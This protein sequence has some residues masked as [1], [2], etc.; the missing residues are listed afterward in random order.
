MHLQFPLLAQHASIKI[1]RVSTLSKHVAGFD[2]I[3]NEKGCFQGVLPSG[4]EV[5]TAY[6]TVAADLLVGSTP[7]ISSRRWMGD[8]CSRRSRALEQSL[9]HSA[10][11]GQ[12][13]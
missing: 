6:F 11:L 1:A 13:E 3:Y 7:C 10:R 8:P 12:A 2:L 4:A 9:Q 5:V